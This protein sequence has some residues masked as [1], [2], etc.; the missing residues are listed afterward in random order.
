MKKTVLALS[1]AAALVAMSGC[2]SFKVGAACY[3]PHG[4]TGQCSAT[5]VAPGVVP[6]GAAAAGGAAQA[7]PQKPPATGV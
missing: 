6:A 5:T 2:S 4:V 3:I 1:I 7:Q